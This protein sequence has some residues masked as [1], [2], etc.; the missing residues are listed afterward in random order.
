MNRKFG[1]RL[2]ACALACLICSMMAAGA[3]HGAEGPLDEKIDLSVRQADP[4]DV[5]RSFGKLMGA[6][7]VVDPAVHGPVS[8]ELHNVR[9]RTLLDAVC[10]SIGCRW[11]LQPG[12]P[13]KLR[14][15]AG[16]AA[17][18]GKPA[19]ADL[20]SGLDE[21]LDLKVTEAKGTEVLKTFA[22]ILGVQLSLDPAVGGEVSFELENTPCRKA[23][24]AVCAALGCDWELVEGPP[25]TLRVT[26]KGRK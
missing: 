8:V 2:E 5:F 16:P 12:K 10:E 9:V 13:P 18:A 26:A 23:L 21:E 17:A 7:T 15:T 4:A 20:R 19:P 24:D 11:E 3:A 14:V 22:Q 25:R 1:R 6:E